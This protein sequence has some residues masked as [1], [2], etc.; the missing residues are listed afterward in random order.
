MPRVT[1]LHRIR[2]R[3]KKADMPV[4]LNEIVLKNINDGEIIDIVRFGLESG[5]EVR[6]LD[7]MPIGAAA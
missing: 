1:R 3:G 7:L 4:K 5:C 2:R 6:F